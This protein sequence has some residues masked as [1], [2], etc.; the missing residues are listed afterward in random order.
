MSRA[1]DYPQSEPKN[2]SQ[3]SRPQVLNGMITFCSIWVSTIRAPYL[4]LPYHPV[5]VLHQHTE[6]GGKQK[7]ILRDI[8]GAMGSDHI[9]RHDNCASRLKNRAFYEKVREISTEDELH[10]PKLV[11]EPGHHP[12]WGQPIWHSSYVSPQ[13]GQKFDGCGDAILHGVGQ[14]PNPECRSGFLWR[15]SE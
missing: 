14:E 12:R 13:Y 7:H 11:L 8:L 5:K 2:T 9:W 6:L 10:K 4:W 15:I 3:L 1:A